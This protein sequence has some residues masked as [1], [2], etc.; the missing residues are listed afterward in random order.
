MV[1]STYTSCERGLEAWLTSKAAKQQR[2]KPQ[3]PTIPLSALP[4]R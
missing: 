2:F 3:N 4:I 1:K